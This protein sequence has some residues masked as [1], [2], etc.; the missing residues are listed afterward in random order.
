MEN[1]E[2]LQRKVDSM[3]KWGIVFSILWLAGI[4]SLCSFILAIKA[5]NL[6]IQTNGEVRG[7]GKV[8]W[9]LIAGGIGMLIWF[10]ILI[11]GIINN[12]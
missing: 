1:T 6:I 3:L 5:R 11:M 4:G 7:M 12:L 9:C 8:W 2:G 10:P